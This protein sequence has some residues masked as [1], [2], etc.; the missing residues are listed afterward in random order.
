MRSLSAIVGELK[1][2][3]AGVQKELDRLSA[4]IHALGNANATGQSRRAVLSRVPRRTLSAAAR[5]KIATAQKARWA[6][7]KAKQKKAA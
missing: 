3:R 5:R 4:A 1:Q 7:L 6:A 2:K